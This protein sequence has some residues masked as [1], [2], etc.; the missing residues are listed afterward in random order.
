[1]NLID[2]RKFNFEVDKIILFKKNEVIFSNIECE[3]EVY[4][5]YFYK[6]TIKNK[7]I[8]KINDNGI[9]TTECAYYNN[10]CF[11]N[12]IYTNSY[13]EK[14]DDIIET[15]IYRINLING[16][17][18]LLYS[19]EKELSVIFLSDSYALLKGSNYEMDDEHSDIKKDLQGEYD[20][21]ILLDLKENVEYEIKDNRVILGIRD[22]FI[23]YE[24]DG[25]E[26]IV[27]EEAYMDDWELEELFDDG[28][29]KEDFYINSYIESINVISLDK[30]V[31]SIKEDCQVIP[32]NQLHK[33]ELTEWTRYFGMD[34]DNIYY[35]TK[36]F[37]SK[38]Q[39]IYS[40]DKKTLEK[41]LL[42]SIQ[43]NGN[44]F[45]YSNNNIRYDIDNRKIYSMKVIDNKIKEIKEIFDEDFTFEYNELRENFKALI[46]NYFITSFWTEDD[47][48]DNSTDFTKI[49]DTKNLTEDIYEGSCLII[50]NNVLLFK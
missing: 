9:I 1:M 18:D 47:N 21:A 19:T 10:F 32:F 15:L 34:D 7:H 12:Y 24:V 8:Y 30:L 13:I 36:D 41:Q 48:G 43:M 40:V 39:K 27:F 33:T 20:Y 4:K 25:I 45:S 26:Y 44:K 16:E 37:E 42:K 3:N 38:I 6:Y 2:L 17:T 29:K 22:Y 23:S 28:L 5:R 49:R 50:E 46:D 35:R 14:N 11:D 31:R